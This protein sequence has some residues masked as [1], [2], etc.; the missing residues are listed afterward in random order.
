MVRPGN[1]IVVFEGIV[2]EDRQHRHA[3]VGDREGDGEA[4]H[5]GD[6]DRGND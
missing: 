1:V 5:G 3:G 4:D 6:A 2:V